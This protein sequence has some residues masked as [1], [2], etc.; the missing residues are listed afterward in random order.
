MALLGTTV[1]GTSNGWVSDCYSNGSITGSQTGIGGLVGTN[2][3][4]D[5]AGSSVGFI[6]NCYITITRNIVGSTYGASILSN[7]FNGQSTLPTVDVLNVALSDIRA[8]SMTGKAW[9]AGTNGVPVL[10]WQ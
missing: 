1:Y 4:S 5:S 9:K 10:Y 6:Y 7:S 2:G 8:G 3:W